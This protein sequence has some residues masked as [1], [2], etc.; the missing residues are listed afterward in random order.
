MVTEQ[1]VNGIPGRTVFGLLSLVRHYLS[2]ERSFSGYQY[3]DVVQ[4]LRK[5]HSGELHLVFEQCRSHAALK[6]KNG[7]LLKLLDHI[8]VAASQ[9]RD[10]GIDR[11]SMI[12]DPAFASYTGP[13]GG[14]QYKRSLVEG[15]DLN[16]FI[17]ALQEISNLVEPEYAIVAN[18]A[19][20]ILIQQER[21][22]VEQ[23]RIELKKAL[24]EAMEATSYVDRVNRID[25]FT[26]QNISIN[27][28]LFYYLMKDKRYQLLVIE[29][30]VRRFVIFFV[31]SFYTSNHANSFTLSAHHWRNPEI[32]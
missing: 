19:Q 20:S 23:R 28:L 11:S 14:K 8:D 7:L 17:P 5:A 31:L 13:R 27:D 9:A 25:K 29:T 3:Q 22:T 2:V 10:Q 18:T 12:G 6:R 1:Y 30:Y 24:I 21:P 4:R 26:D 32:Y 15:T 16:A